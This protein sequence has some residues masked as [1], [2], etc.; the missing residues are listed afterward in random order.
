[1]RVLRVLT[2]GFLLS[3]CSVISIDFTPRIQPLGEQTVEGAGAAKVLLMD[4][5]GVISEEPLFTRRQR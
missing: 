5:S 4:L 1:M 2:L 3:A